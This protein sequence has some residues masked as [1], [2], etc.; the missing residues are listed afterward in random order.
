MANKTLTIKEFKMWLEG[1]EEMQPDGW[2]PSE[3][4]WKRIREK[5]NMI[6]ES[7][8]AVIESYRPPVGQSIPRGPDVQAPA[9]SGMPPGFPPEFSTL[10]RPSGPPPTGPFATDG[11]TPVKTPNVDTSNGKGYTSTFT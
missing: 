5:I 9:F 8:P 6:D 2:V 11:G 1:V 7:Q 10:P 3:T 4:Q